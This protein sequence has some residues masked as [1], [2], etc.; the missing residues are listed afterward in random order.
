M[1]SVNVTKR[2]LAFIRRAPCID[3][4]MAKPLGTK[5]AASKDWLMLR[6]VSNY[7]FRRWFVT[8]GSDDATGVL[9]CYTQ[10]MLPKCKRFAHQQP[11]MNHTLRHKWRKFETGVTPEG[12]LVLLNFNC[13]V[14]L[15]LKM[16]ITRSVGKLRHTPHIWGQSYSFYGIVLHCHFTCAHK[17]PRRKK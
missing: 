6:A 12:V 7:G 2:T 5:F 1:C 17:T 11:E 4:K 10:R 16:S 3:L 9:F 15:R 13:H 14:T 8:R